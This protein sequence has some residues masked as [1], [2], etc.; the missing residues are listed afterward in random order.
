MRTISKLKIMAAALVMGLF[1][2]SCVIHR[3][4]P[5]PPRHKKHHKHRKPPRK[6]HKHH[7]A[8]IGTE[9]KGGTFYAP[10][11]YA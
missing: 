5:R 10:C 4:H 9:M 1:C 7:R 8:D 2:S 3:D 11:W 6:H